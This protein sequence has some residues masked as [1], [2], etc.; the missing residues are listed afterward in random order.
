MHRAREETMFQ[1]L[2]DRAK[3][4]IYYALAL[5]LGFATLLLAPMFGAL[6]T[7][8]YMFTPLLAVL[9]MLLVV[10]RDGYTKAGWAALGLR[11]RG[12]RA[13]GLAVLLPCLTLGF[14]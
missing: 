8:L 14:G 2:T 13:W 1:N 5:S 6:I 3:A 4:A 7:I 9:L 10:T 12:V 11:H